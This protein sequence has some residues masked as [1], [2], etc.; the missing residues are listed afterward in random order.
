MGGELFGSETEKELMANSAFNLVNVARS[1]WD[2]SRSF[3]PRNDCTKAFSREYSVFRYVTDGRTDSNRLQSVLVR[4]SEGQHF[5]FAKGAPGAV[6]ALMDPK[7]LPANFSARVA[8]YANKGFKCLAFGFRRVEEGQLGL[9]DHQLQIQLTFAGLYLFKFRAP[10]NAAEV[11]RTLQSSSIN[12]ILM[13]SGPVF[14]GVATARNTEVIPSDKKVVLLQT[15]VVGGVE[16]FLVTLMEPKVGGVSVNESAVSSDRLD[17]VRMEDSSEKDILKS[18]DCL[19][20]TGKAFSLLLDS[21]PS[22]CVQAVLDRCRV[23]GDLSDAERTRV[24]RMLRERN[25]QQPVA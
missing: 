17:V 12:V 8:K 16:R 3:I 14:E 4:D 18:N 5:L 7:S 22:E 13:S 11:A 1:D 15:E 6:E 10:E 2:S 23:Y 19:A 24:L 9:P 25:G 20:V 21:E